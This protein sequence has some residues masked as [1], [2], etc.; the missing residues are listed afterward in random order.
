MDD[1]VVVGGRCAGASTALLLARAGLRVRLVERSR[2]LGDVVSGHLIKPTGA[3][4]LRRWGLLDELLASGPPPLPDRVLWVD[5]RPFPAPALPP[6]VPAPFAPRRTL[7]DPF[8]LDAAR[9]AGVTVELGATVTGLLTTGGRV[10]GVETA[11]GS[12]PARLVVG[13]DGRTSRLAGLVGATWTSWAPPVTYSYYGYWRGSAITALHVW[14][15]RGRFFGLFPTGDDLALVFVQAPAAG[16]AD[17]RSAALQTYVGELRAR[18]PLRELLG[19][20]LLVE[21]LRGMGDL[22][23]FFRTSAGP[24][25]VLVGDAGHHKDPLVARGITDAFRDA[26]L[27]LAGTA[28]GWNGTDDVLDSALAAYPA[29]R[30]RTARPLAEANVAL[31]RLDRDGP[32]LARAWQDMTR[33]E[34]S[35]DAGDSAAPAVAGR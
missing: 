26:E 8:L 9:A 34:Q 5:G 15:E 22:P 17:V 35:L 4:V 11:A 18:R 28:E 14:L 21:R 25:W 6:G 27:V 29:R 19:D 16:F 33:L 3:Q 10:S 32:D 13:A 24:G 23:T 31:A 20:G 1:V 2:R 7:L 30:D 12:R